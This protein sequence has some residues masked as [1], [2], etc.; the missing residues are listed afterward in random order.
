MILKLYIR[1][2]RDILQD[3][4]WWLYRDLLQKEL[5]GFSL[6]DFWQE[7]VLKYV[8]SPY[9]MTHPYPLELNNNNKN[10]SIF[11]KTDLS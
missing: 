2:R 3:L 6:Q 5:Q 1:E 8:F 11:I 10:K 7:F 9:Y 4:S